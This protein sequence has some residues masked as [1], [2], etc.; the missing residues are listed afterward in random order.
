[1]KNFLWPVAILIFY[2]L[3]AFDKVKDASSDVNFYLFVVIIFYAAYRVFNDKHIYSINMFFWIFNLIFLGY[4]ASFQYLT[5]SFPWANKVTDEIVFETNIYILLGFIVYDLIYYFY[6]PSVKSGE[7]FTITYPKFNFYY[8]GV[9]LFGIAWILIYRSTGIHFT[10]YETLTSQDKPDS[11]S[12]DQGL[13]VNLTLRS[14]IVFFSILNI[15]LLRVKKV[16]PLFAITII[17]LSILICFPTTVARNF[18]GVFY[19]GLCL[20]Y[21]RTFKWKKLIPSVFILIFVVLFPILTYARHDYFSADYVLKNFSAM[22]SDAYKSGDFDAY[23]MFG[24]SIGYVQ[25]HGITYGRQLMGAVLFFVPRTIW[26]DKP[27]GSG[28]FIGEKL[29]LGFLNVSCP[30]MAEGVINFGLL[31]LIVFIAAIA[32]LFK[33]LDS[34]Y[35]IRVKT[36]NLNNFWVILYPS[37]IGSFTFIMRGDL[38]SSSAYTVGLLA[39][40]LVMH[41]IFKFKV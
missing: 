28:Y 4:T 31:G 20:N 8:L 38:L 17:V 10:R 33:K 30:F 6:K 11:M 21:F 5:D 40:A 2:L 39:S 22:T 9:I 19:L 41:S 29:G 14:F 37:L 18:G 13:L 36:N 23:S 1:M 24:R 35:W 16:I 3:Q 15:H 27:Y 7:R 26:P 32:V 34:F 25:D 12:Q